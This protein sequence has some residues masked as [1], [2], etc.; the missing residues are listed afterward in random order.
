MKLS[1]KENSDSCLNVTLDLHSKESYLRT[2]DQFAV[3]LKNLQGIF[4]DLE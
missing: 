3:L 1:M 2:S 4:V